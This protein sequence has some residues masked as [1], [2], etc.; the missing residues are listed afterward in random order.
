M[1]YKKSKGRLLGD[2]FGKAS[3]F[4]RQTD[5][6]VKIDTDSSGVVSSSTTVANTAFQSFVANTNSAFSDYWP[7]ANVI[8]HT[9]K[10]LEV[11]N[12]TST[13]TSSLATWAALIATNTSIRSAIST[14]VSNLVDSAPSTLDTLNELAAALGDDANFATTVTTSLAGKAANSY[15]N[16]TFVSNTAFQSFV[17]N[18]NS[19]FSNYWPSANVISYVAA[20]AGSGSTVVVSD[21]APSSPSEG[22]LWFN[23]TN[24]KT[25]IYYSSS[26]VQ[27]NPA[28]SAGVSNTAFQSF[29]AN[30]NSYIAY[31][32]ATERS[33]LAN[34]NTYIATK[35]DTSTFNSALANT[36]SY[37]AYVAANAGEVSNSYLTSTY[38]SNTA[39]QSFVANTNA[40]IAA[41]AGGGLLWDGSTN[42]YSNTTPAVDT[43]PS[44]N[45]SLW[46]NST[47]GAIYICTDNTSNANIWTV[48][49]SL[50]DTIQI[51]PYAFQGS[52][53]GYASGGLFDTT[54]DKFPFA[55]DGNATDVGDL[56]V[57]RCNAAGH[58]SSSYGYTSAGQT[59]VT[60]TIDKFPFT[61]DSNASDVG[62]LTV[63][64]YGVAGQSSETHGY[65]TGGWK[66]P[67][68][69]E[70]IDQFPFATDA[71]ATNIGNL[72]IPRYETAGQ[73]SADYGYDSG[74][75]NPTYPYDGTRIYK[76]PF[77][78]SF[79]WTST[80]GELSVDRYWSAGQSSTD[81]GYT[82]G[83]NTPS[84][85]NV[86]DK[87]PFSS[88]TNASDVGDLTVARTQTAGQSSTDY[89][90]TT[91]GYPGPTNVI[92]KFSF[93]SDSN[94]TD[95]GDL[96]S[97]RYGPAGQQY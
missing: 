8:S 95:V 1:A 5:D 80:V 54:I 42:F 62:D 16:S 18:T 72:S 29:V 43:N 69:N 75:S 17:A 32:S 86:I 96:S 41:S 11:A 47:T 45:G 34:T 73:S 21:T 12:V 4:S 60:N 48:T 94:A 83:G 19:A 79:S 50:A 64:R 81:Y 3:I 87:F 38:T 51:I 52:N 37:I 84:V 65:T 44:A 85:S 93:S 35:V 70:V 58:S 88:D 10:Y 33:A 91:G 97:G 2:L 9:A 56:T 59:P 14:E 27:S 31:V 68:Y 20:S 7:S 26:W 36:N 76:F 40:A 63:A 25:F 46:V 53:Y 90:Y 67:G 30:T 61:S 66:Q 23:S 55:S 77:S 89:G 15:V 92:D 49:S 57:A 6:S 82:T 13:D 71:N 74:G 39:F 24:L 78:S 28:A 22:D